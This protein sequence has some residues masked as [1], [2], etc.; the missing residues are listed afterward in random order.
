MLRT[1]RL[2]ADEVLIDIVAAGYDAGVP[3]GEQAAR[4]MMATPIAP[5]WRMAEFTP[6]DCFSSHRC[7]GRRRI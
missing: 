2:A 4:D 3:L 5:D 1:K 7:L 6:P